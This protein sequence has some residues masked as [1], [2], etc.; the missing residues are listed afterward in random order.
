MMV[1]LDLSS[2]PR[3][4]LEKCCVSTNYWKGLA[5]DGGAGQCAPADP[6][7]SGGP[8]ALEPSHLISV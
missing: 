2:S 3:G 4:E 5:L 7:P 6:S 8:A 1:S